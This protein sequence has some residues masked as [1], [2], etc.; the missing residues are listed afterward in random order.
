MSKIQSLLK[1]QASTYP[2]LIIVTQVSDSYEGLEQALLYG[3][4]KVLRIEHPELPCRHIEWKS[5]DEQYLMESQ[6]VPKSIDKSFHFQC[7]DKSC[8]LITGGLGDLGFYVAQYL[9]EQKNLKNVILVGRSKP[10]VTLIEKIAQLERQG[11][12][13]L[14]K[15][16]DI[17]KESQVF[18]LFAELESINSSLK[19][20]FFTL[21]INNLSLIGLFHAGTWFIQLTSY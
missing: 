11:A 10:S 7:H 3:L 14:I 12:R 16:I 2:E 8:F 5:Q 9:V 13:V 19:L 18:D 1:S 20:L 17:S 15:N 6:L 21:F 4:I